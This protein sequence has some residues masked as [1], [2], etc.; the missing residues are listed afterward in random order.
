MSGGDL[1]LLFAESAPEEIQL[2]VII[3]RVYIAL[4]FFLGPIANGFE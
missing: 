2:S 3:L 1:P 4:S